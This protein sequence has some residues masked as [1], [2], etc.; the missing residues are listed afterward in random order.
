MYENLSRL[1]IL[2]L[3]VL[4]SEGL[5]S[6]IDCEILFCCICTFRLRID[7]RYFLK[8]SIFKIKFI[9]QKLW[10]HHDTEIC[11]KYQASKIYKL[12]PS[13]PNRLRIPQSQSNRSYR[14]EK[15]KPRNFELNVD[16]EYL[17]SRIHISLVGMI[18]V[19]L[20]AIQR[21]VF[22]RTYSESSKNMRLILRDLY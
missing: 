11:R 4:K 3:Q 7:G 17:I 6:I 22:S 1:M 14:P 2:K 9:V 12:Q 10:M 18:L 5:F 20:L 19:T 15:W 13:T 16:F 21:S 8:Y